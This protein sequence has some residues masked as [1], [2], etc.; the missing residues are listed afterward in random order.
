MK[1]V[2]LG[3]AKKA[4]V[5]SSCREAAGGGGRSGHR[6]EARSQV[7]DTWRGLQNAGQAEEGSQMADPWRGL[8]KAGQA[9][10]RNHMTDPWRVCRAWSKT[11]ESKHADER[12]VRKQGTSV[13]RDGMPLHK[14]DEGLTKGSTW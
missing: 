2:I 3:S 14:L 4:V 8:Q 9:E 6:G 13:G 7:T 1:E 12:R 11:S 5:R 10:E